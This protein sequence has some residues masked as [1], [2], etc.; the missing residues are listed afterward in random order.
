M[1]PYLTIL[2]KRFCPL[3]IYCRSRRKTE[4]K[5][6]VV[7]SVFFWGGGAQKFLINTPP[8]PPNCSDDL[9]LFFCLHPFSMPLPFDSG[10]PTGRNPSA[11]KTPNDVTAP[12]PPYLLLVNFAHVCN[13]FVAFFE[14]SALCCLI[15]GFD[16]GCQI[17]KNVTFEYNR[18]AVGRS[19]H[20]TVHYTNSYVRL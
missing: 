3:P 2:A 6:K 17:R 11:Q 4:E 19:C 10:R 14:I 18:G 8:P 1:N 9:C 7:A 15:D 5:S 16:N 13:Y 12:I 20:N